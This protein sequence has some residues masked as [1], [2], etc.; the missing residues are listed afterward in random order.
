MRKFFLHLTITTI[1]LLLTNS[2]DTKEEQIPSFISIDTPQIIINDEQ[3]EGSN[4]HKI[5]DIW[6]YIDNKYQGNYQPPRTF[7]VLASGHHLITLRA[8]IM[9]NG[10]SATRE[11][12]PFYHYQ[13]IDTILIEDQTLKLTPKF[14]YITN[15]HFWIEDFQDPNFSIGDN[16][17]LISD[18]SII[19]I[20]DNNNPGNFIGAAFTDAGHNRFMASTNKETDPIYY[21]DAERRLFLELDYKC[22]THFYIGLLG[23]KL[24]TVLLVNTSENWNKIYVDL[25]PSIKSNPAQTYALAFWMFYDGEKQCQLFLDNIKLV[26]YE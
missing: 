3:K 8:G 16:P 6:V 14:S 22:N 25:T 17:Q 18:T 19:R 1:I 10:I 2:C 15:A 20:E 9:R 11:E 21:S 4:T 13:D 12:Y 24:T 26:R 7:P 23:E 5:T